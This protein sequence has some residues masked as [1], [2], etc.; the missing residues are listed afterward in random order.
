[1]HGKSTVNLDPEITGRL[2]CTTRGGKNLVASFGR[3]WV[4]IENPKLV[5]AIGQAAHTMAPME[6]RFLAT[7]SSPKLGLSAAR[8]PFHLGFF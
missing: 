4:E 6:P 1:M 7:T 3:P 2:V 5:A 8:G